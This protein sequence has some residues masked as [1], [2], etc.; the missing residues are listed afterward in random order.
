M[1]QPRIAHVPPRARSSG[2]GSLQP[3]KLWQAL[4]DK[5]RDQILNALSRVVADHLT[6][7]LLPREV[8][9]ERH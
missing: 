4:A 6:K 1:S 5:D 3:K 7:A 9:H 8:T 2:R